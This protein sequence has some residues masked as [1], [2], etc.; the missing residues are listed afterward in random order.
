MERVIQSLQL[1]VELGP[2]TDREMEI[3]PQQG[4]TSRQ[5]SKEIKLQ[6]K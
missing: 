3:S 5:A 4:A 6:L 2:Q 1:E